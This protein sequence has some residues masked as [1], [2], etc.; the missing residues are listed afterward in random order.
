MQDKYKKNEHILLITPPTLQLETYNSPFVISILLLLTI[1]RLDARNRGV[2]Y[3]L[4]D[5]SNNG[6][7]R[8]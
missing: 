6:R 2:R 5:I 4:I 3:L 7:T 1:G 8:C